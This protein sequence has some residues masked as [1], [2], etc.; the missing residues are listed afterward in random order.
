MEPFVLETGLRDVAFNGRLIEAESLGREAHITTQAT[1]Q[2]EIT[3]KRVMISLNE[4]G[5]TCAPSGIII[6]TERKALRVS[7]V[8]PT[9]PAW[10]LQDPLDL[11]V[12]DALPAITINAGGVYWFPMASPNA[13]RLSLRLA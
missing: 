2:F 7:A 13:M 5:W 4:R 10:S 9:M 11:A 6:M 1:R 3:V 12:V 8:A